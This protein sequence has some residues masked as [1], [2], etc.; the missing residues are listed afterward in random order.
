MSVCVFPVPGGPYKR[1]TP[2]VFVQ[3]SLITSV[4]VLLYFFDTC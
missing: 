1:L 3:I 2:A 4:Y